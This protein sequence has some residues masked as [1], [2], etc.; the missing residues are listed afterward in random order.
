MTSNLPYYFGLARFGGFRNNVFT[1]F[2]TR[3]PKSYDS[4]FYNHA[5]AFNEWMTEGEMLDLGNPFFT[6]LPRP[7]IHFSARNYIYGPELYRQYL[8][9]FHPGRAQELK[10]EP[11]LHYQTIQFPEAELSANLSSF[12]RKL[13]ILHHLICKDRL[14]QLYKQ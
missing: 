4:H 9:E 10:T 11:R 12:D 14:V 2:M 8:A 5:V 13:D 1:L 6:R 7:F 3:A